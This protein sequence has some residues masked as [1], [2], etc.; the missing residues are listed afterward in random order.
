MTLRPGF[1]L[2]ACP[3]GLTPGCDGASAVAS[4]RGGSR[5]TGRAE[6]GEGALAAAMEMW[7]D[8]GCPGGS[9]GDGSSTH[10]PGMPLLPESATAAESRKGLG[11]VGRQER[12]HRKLGAGWE[13]LPFHFIGCVNGHNPPK[14]LL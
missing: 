6:T 8:M 9:Q 1:G 11:Q 10:I 14:T 2:C 5:E 12:L 3:H 4:A 13:W 7:R